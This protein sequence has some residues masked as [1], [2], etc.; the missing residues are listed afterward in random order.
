MS[1]RRK[2]FISYHKADTDEVNN[3]IKTFDDHHDVFIY[4]AIREMDDNIINSTDHDYIM[5]RIRELYLSDSTVTIVLI[6]RCTWSR[7]YVDWEIASTLRN[8]AINKRSGLLAIT[9][10]SVANER[11]KTLPSRFNANLNGEN[12]YAKW[13]KYPTGAVSLANM[14]EQAFQARTLRSHLVDNSSQLFTNNPTC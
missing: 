1:I 3:F 14:I 5:R 8:D 13:Y 10:P 9:L 6:G 12:G 4:R 2:C 7:K 11:S